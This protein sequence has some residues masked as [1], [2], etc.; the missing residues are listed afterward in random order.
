MRALRRRN[1]RAGICGYLRQRL[2]A[3]GMTLSR[4]FAAIAFIAM[5]T[6]CGETTDTEVSSDNG[7]AYGEMF[8]D[9]LKAFGSDQAEGDADTVS[10]FNAALG[11]DESTPYRFAEYVGNGYEHEH[12]CVVSADGLFVAFVYSSKPGARVLMGRGACSTNEA[13]AEVVGMTQF[14]SVDDL[15]VSKGAQL[16]GDRSSK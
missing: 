8:S 11:W 16:F 14:A 1:R 7:A 12:Y 5:I 2:Y 10:E 13:D 4:A 15:D 3:S 6:A 9:V